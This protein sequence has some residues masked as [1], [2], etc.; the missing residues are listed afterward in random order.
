MAQAIG[1]FF[2]EIGLSVNKVSKV[3]T[4]WQTRLFENTKIKWQKVFVSKY[5]FLGMGNSNVGL[6]NYGQFC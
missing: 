1:F 5:M 2:F 3:L 4:R 6:I